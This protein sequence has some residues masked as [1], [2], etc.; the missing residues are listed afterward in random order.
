LHAQTTSTWQSCPVIT[1]MPADLDTIAPLE[2]RRR[3]ELR[4][5]HGDA[6]TVIAYEK[7]N[8]VPALVIPTLESYPTY[9]AHI[10]SVLVLQCV[11]GSADHVYVFVFRKGIPAVGLK[12]S[13]KEL[14]QVK[15]SQDAVTVLIA[16]SAFPSPNE[17]WPKRTAKEYAFPIED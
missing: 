8:P 17:T 3:F 9:L 1:T 7:S 4:Q 12:T 10:R 16:P 6:I 5:C 15:Q 2:T 13:T 14:I 11:G